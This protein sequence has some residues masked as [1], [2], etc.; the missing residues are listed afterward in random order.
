MKGTREPRAFLF[1]LLEP[2]RRN[3]R[4]ASALPNGEVPTMFSQARLTYP[5]LNA[6]KQ[7]AEG[8]W[9]ID[10]P[11]IRF[12]ALAIPFSTRAT[13]IRIGVDLFVHSP[14]PVTRQL[15]AEG[16]RHRCR[17]LDRR[18]KPVALLVGGGLATRLP[19]RG[20][21]CRAEGRRG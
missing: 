14:T 11:V 4:Q 9:I 7:V 2:T 19:A 5:P 20:S 13:I 12:G 6:L 1:A 10:G 18:A 16:R 21:F 15:G 17:A 3:G 8:V